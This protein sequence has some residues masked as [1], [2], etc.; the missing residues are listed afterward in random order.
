MHYL[1]IKSIA[2]GYPVS[3]CG[4]VSHSMQRHDTLGRRP[5]AHASPRA[6]QGPPGPSITPFPLLHSWLDLCCQASDE[7]RREP[8]PKPPARLW[9]SRA[10]PGP[11]CLAVPSGV[12]ALPDAR[13]QPPD[14]CSLQAF[15]TR[16][17]KGRFPAAKTTQKKISFTPSLL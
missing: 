15:G 14:P 5:G 4:V 2:S 7:E 9:G 16:Q 13:L 6:P 8:C 10:V 3:H 12:P 11:S 1:P 17:S